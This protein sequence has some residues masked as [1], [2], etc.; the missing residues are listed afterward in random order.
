MQVYLI[1]LENI[2]I[3]IKQI[4]RRSL[5]MTRLRRLRMVKICMRWS[6][7]IITWWK[8]T[9]SCAYLQRLAY[10]VH[11]LIWLFCIFILFL[12]AL[13]MIS[14][15]SNRQYLGVNSRR[16]YST[17]SVSEQETNGQTTE[18]KASKYN[19]LY[20]HLVISIL[21]FEKFWNILCEYV[22]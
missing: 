11:F 21:S 9:H 16:T 6:S 18:N 17:A 10:L 13:T 1:A 19:M 8:Y 2:S 12:N 5:H 14:Y 7:F 22:Q 3:Y 4:V 20:S 15:F